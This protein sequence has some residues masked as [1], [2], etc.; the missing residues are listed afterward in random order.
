MSAFG[1][2]AGVQKI[3]F[4]GF[5]T[6]G[7]YLICGDTGAGKTTIFDAIS[8]ALFG[9]P[10][11]RERRAQMLR[12][13]F[14]AP[15]VKTYVD[16]EFDLRGGRYRVE[17]NP[18][19]ERP[20]ARGSGVTTETANATL[21]LPDGRIVGGYGA[22][23]NKITDLLGINREQFSQ[24]VMLAQGDFLQL[25]LSGTKERSEILRRIFATGNIESFQ[26]RL[27]QWSDGLEQDFMEERR[28][29]LQRTEHIVLREPGT[30]KGKSAN[31]DEA[32]AGADAGKAAD[33]TDKADGAGGDTA[34]G[35]GSPFC[36]I[37]EW[38]AERNFHKKRELLDALGLLLNELEAEIGLAEREQAE[39]RDGLNRY[40][41]R[42]AL[43]VDVNRRFDEFENVR[44]NIAA[45]TGQAESIEMK[46][47]RRNSGAAALRLIFP[48]EEK[49]I[50]AQNAY[51]DLHGAIAAAADAAA[52]AREASVK[53]ES[54][55][56]AEEAKE[57]ERMRLIAEIDRLNGQI[58]AYERLSVLRNDWRAAS[59]DAV[60]TQNINKALESERIITDTR[61]VELR[62][63]SEKL[64]DARIRLERILSKIGRHEEART[65]VSALRDSLDFCGEK[66]RELIKIKNEY[67]IAERDFDKADSAYKHAEKIFL[68]EQAGI[69]A[70]ALRDGEPCPVCGSKDHP[71]AACLTSE[72]PTEAQV[73]AAKKI[74]EDARLSRERLSAKC[75]ALTAELDVLERN[76]RAEY[77]RIINFQNMPWETPLKDSEPDI[78]DPAYGETFIDVPVRRETFTDNISKI[79]NSL[80]RALTGFNE[81]EKSERAAAARAVTCE[82]DIAAV[83]DILKNNERSRSEN[84]VAL[85]AAAEK[86]A[87]LKAEGETLKQTLSYEDGKKA[88]EALKKATGDLSKL[89]ALLDAAVAERERARQKYEAAAAVLNERNAKIEPVTDEML[90][91]KAGYLEAIAI[92]GFTDEAAYREALLGEDEITRI[93]EELADYSREADFNAR[94]NARLTAETNG[95]EYA[96]LDALKSHM[97]EIEDRSETLNRRLAALRGDLDANRAVYRDLTESCVK[98]LEKESEWMSAKSVSDTANGLLPGKM[99][100]S[101]EIWLHSA[102]FSRILRAANRR[103]AIMSANRYEL[104]RRTEAADKRVWA[105]LELDVHDYYTGKRRDVRSLSGGESF[106]ASL[107]L[108]LGLSDVV[109]SAAGGVRL[110]AMFIDEGFGSLDSDSL[111]AAIS[112]LQDVAGGNRVVGVISHVNELASRIDR[113]IRIARGRSGSRAEVIV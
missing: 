98:L 82:K 109:Q 86:L 89:R 97:T 57:P 21:Y 64:K 20:K 94:E 72:A 107:A 69:L 78:N 50:A 52:A 106:K 83:T 88:A 70:A 79:E 11:G 101:F 30:A 60:K 15:S 17:R 2:Y 44:K 87:A 45:L 23:T 3:D 46:R 65:A 14:A 93:D 7:L 111:D 10:S 76:C 102:F 5:G 47:S 38:M 34:A 4:S 25:L 58:P 16:L 54:S 49:Y 37:T 81:E 108:A 75:G 63:E 6:G 26:K 90:R 80:K 36:R 19:Y 59:E 100:I 51:N 74:A 32:D 53:A 18:D 13:D 62:L 85:T 33:G 92:N 29:F 24:I 12:S 112:T 66:S 113:Q 1:P 22:V 9:T 95:L 71:D 110:D 68:R 35:G 96:D 41:A 48:S 91:T 8:F 103:F 27:K 39:V 77:A 31:A 43:A 28:R 55:Y 61:L 56:A 105:G 84:A 40:T 42:M 67:I 104:L 99:K 73:N